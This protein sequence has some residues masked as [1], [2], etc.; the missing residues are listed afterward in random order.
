MRVVLRLVVFLV[1]L[2]V[3]LVGV[4]FVLP[5]TSH[6]ERSVT[7]DR[8]AS[9]LYLLLSSFRRFNEWSPWHARDPQATYTYTGPAEGVGAT[10]AWSSTHPDVGNGSQT[11]AALTPGKSVDA[12]LDFGDMGKPSARYTLEPQ[13]VGTKVTWSLDSSL[14]INL[15]GGFFW[16]VT[17]RYMGLFMDRMVGPDFEQGLRSLKSLAET[18][19]NVDIA[20]LEPALVD[21]APRKIVYVTG[22]VALE[23]PAAAP[24]ALK[25]ALT[26]VWRFASEK[27]LAIE[28]QPLTLTRA[29]D[30]S[31]WTFDAGVGAAWDVMP[32]DASVLGGESP[33]GRAVR[34]VHEGAWKDL[35]RT[36]QRAYG[37]IAVKG[38]RTRD[39]LMQEYSGDVA[40]PAVKVTVSIPVE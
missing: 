15:D 10:L 36:V 9:Q 28:G 39:R 20:G 5:S 16:N 35:A 4:A 7:I 27:Q 31:T 29:N 30:G 26:Q 8:P 23:D 38:Y 6:V 14:P 22:S 33:A 21:L 2:C 24:A 40:A 12:A 3:A 37:W 1:L 11:I 17:G 25:N 34:V 13:S 32:Q 19:P 18:F